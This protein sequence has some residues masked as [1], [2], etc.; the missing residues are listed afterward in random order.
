MY[1][2]IAYRISLRNTSLSQ[3]QD[4]LSRFGDFHY[5]D[6]TVVRLS[7]LYDRNSHA[8]KTASL[9]W[10]HPWCEISPVYS[11]PFSRYNVL[12][13]CTVHGDDNALLYTT[14]QNGGNVMGKRDFTKLTFQIAPEG[15]EYI[16]TGCFIDKCMSCGVSLSQHQIF[17][18]IKRLKE[19]TLSIFCKY[20]TPIYVWV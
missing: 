17:L 2:T 15:T 3:Y 1:G 20:V 13:F 14:L 10:N 11:I 12:K 8:A 18:I 5:K 6:E 19:S 7:Y 4:R 9:Y 16:A